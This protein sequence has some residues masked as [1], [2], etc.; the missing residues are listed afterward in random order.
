MSKVTSDAMSDLN[1]VGELAAALRSANE[2]IEALANENRML[3]DRIYNRTVKI[4][5][6]TKAVQVLPSGCIIWM[7]AVNDKGYGVTT[8]DKKPAYTHRVS[9]QQAHGLIPKGDFFVCH[10]CDVPSCINP[11]HLFL[12]TCADNVA[13]M[14]IKGR[15]VIFSPS[16][17]KNGNSKL[18]ASD[19][20]QIKA[21]RQNG[22]EL[23]Q[24]AMEYNVSISAISRICSNKAWQGASV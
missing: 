7:G 9:Y 16:G 12:G 13:D 14:I 8:K 5:E 2:A 4:W 22:F 11:A 3:R 23:S 19:V 18:Q 17:E 6:S 20:K 10:R 21:K 1:S 15:K 24:L